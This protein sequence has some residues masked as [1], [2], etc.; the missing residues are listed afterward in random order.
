[1]QKFENKKIKYLKSSPNGLYIK[2]FGEEIKFFTKGKVNLSSFYFTQKEYLE[3]CNQKVK[4][5]VKKN[6]KK[7]MSNANIYKDL[8]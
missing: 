4:D 5:K 6:Y 7:K 2:Y 8:L 1:M 3:I